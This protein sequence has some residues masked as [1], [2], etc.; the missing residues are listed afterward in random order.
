MAFEPVV[1]WAP[2]NRKKNQIRL[3]KEPP[4]D[5]HV[6]CLGKLFCFHFQSGLQMHWKFHISDIIIVL[7]ILNILPSYDLRVHC[8]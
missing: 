2:T 1:V 7:C 4:N 3:C 6:I 8:L 5:M